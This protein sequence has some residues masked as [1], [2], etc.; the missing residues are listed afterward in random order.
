[1]HLFCFFRPK[2]V[3]A[4]AKNEKSA[5]EESAKRLEGKIRE[6]EEEL[7]AQREDA[8]EMAKL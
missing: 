8:L 4:L 6:L 7:E 1:M 2:T 3:E 5:A